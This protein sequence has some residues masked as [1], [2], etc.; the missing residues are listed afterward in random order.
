MS[1]DTKNLYSNLYSFIFILNSSYEK[2]KFDPV[3]TVL[4]NWSMIREPRRG[5]DPNAIQVGA[6]G[7]TCVSSRQIEREGWPFHIS[8][9]RFQARL[10]LALAALFQVYSCQRLLAS[11]IAISCVRSIKIS[12]DTR[13]R[14]V[15]RC[16]CIVLFSRFIFTPGLAIPSAYNPRRNS[17]SNPHRETER[18]TWRLYLRAMNLH[19]KFLGENKFWV[20]KMSFIRTYKQKIWIFDR[21]N[22]TPTGCPAKRYFDP[23]ITFAFTL[24]T[25]VI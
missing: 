6:T 7:I 8:L 17:G 18:V 16:E 22:F 24:I 9:T 19:A 1:S 5:L 10:F 2:N 11:S 15:A 20:E 4:G 14:C 25:S 21:G 23:R 12:S 13:T 3:R